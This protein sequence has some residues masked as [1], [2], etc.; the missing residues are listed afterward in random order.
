MKIYKVTRNRAK[1]TTLNVKE[2]INQGKLLNMIILY[3]KVSFT[4]TI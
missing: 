4:M 2:R 1:E 3:Q